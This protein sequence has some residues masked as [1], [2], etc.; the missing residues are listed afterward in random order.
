MTTG[1]PEYKAWCEIMQKPELVT[2]A[3][4]T[5]I[6]QFV[7]DMGLRPSAEHK[8]VRLDKKLQYSKPNCFWADKKERNLGK[9]LRHMI[10]YNGKTQNLSQWCRELG[11][12]RR[13][14]SSRITNLGWNPIKAL[15]TPFEKIKNSFTTLTINGK[16]KPIAY[17]KKEFEC[18]LSKACLYNRISK[19]K[20]THKQ[21]L[22]T[23]LMRKRKT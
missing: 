15:T 20:M 21:A 16:T 22:T 7:R 12:P 13:Q 8:I 19:M 10:T 2:D 11:M 23:P 14:V 18:T 1:T 5:N 9:Q 3:W 4:T 6:T 17:W